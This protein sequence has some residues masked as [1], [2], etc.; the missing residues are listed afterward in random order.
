MFDTTWR[1]HPRYNF[2]SKQLH[3]PNLNHQA[4]S[5][6]QL[7]GSKPV[8]WDHFFI[9]LTEELYTMLD[10]TCSPKEMKELNKF[11]T[12]CQVSSGNHAHVFIMW[13]LNSS[14]YSVM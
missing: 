10:T 7:K 5:S 2:T 3:G 6:D 11:P 9:R 12:A 8:D 4:K 1:G 13:D 14:A